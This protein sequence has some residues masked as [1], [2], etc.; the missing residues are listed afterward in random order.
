MKRIKITCF[1]AAAIL[2]I[3]IIACSEK[4]EKEDPKPTTEPY[5]IGGFN[6][7]GASNALFSVSD[8]RQVHFSRGNLQYRAST[9]TWRFAENQ[10]DFL[11]DLNSNISDT[12]DGWIDLFGYGTSGWIQ[13]PYC[14]SSNEDDYYPNNLTGEG[15]NADWGI[16]NSISNGGNIP[17]LWRTLTIDEWTYLFSENRPGKWA[18]AKIANN[19]VGVI[20]LPDIWV[21]PKDLTFIPG[22]ALSWET[23]QYTMEEWLMM[24]NAGAI[25]LPAAGGR[26]GTTIYNVNYSGGCWS[27][28]MG[29]SWVPRDIGYGVNGIDTNH[30][31]N[32]TYGKNVRLVLDNPGQ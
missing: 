23:N 15:A 28:T 16:Y 5:S 14:T 30:S 22:A 3:A 13:M 8:T 32:P 10:Y 26:M 9:N 19:Y 4:S 25:F 12:Y 24:E 11:G 29:S 18:L 27:S 17:G 21:L 20:I 2:S 7:L 6:E 31:D 1:I